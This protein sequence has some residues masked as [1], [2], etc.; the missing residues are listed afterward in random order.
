[1][2]AYNAASFELA[3]ADEIVGTFG[4][5]NFIGLTG[6]NAEV[7]I[8]YELDTVMVNLSAG[9]GQTSLSTIGDETDNDS[10]SE[11]WA[12]L[13]ADHGV[14]DDNPPLQDDPDDI[15]EDA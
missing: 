7:V 12:A 4:E 2:T 15:L 8:D 10:S 1:M 3:S 13:T 11:L 14:F 6:Q 5:I 9:S